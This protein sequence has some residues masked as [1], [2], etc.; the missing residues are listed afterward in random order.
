MHNDTRSAQA[1]KSDYGNLRSGNQA[2]NRH[3]CVFLCNNY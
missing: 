1:R 2:Y 3:T